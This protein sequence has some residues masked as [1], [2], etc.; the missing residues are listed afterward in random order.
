MGVPRSIAEVGTDIDRFQPPNEDWLALDALVTEF[1]ES[2]ATA[3]DA[4]TLLRVFERYPDEDGA[5]VFW[6]LVHGLEEL[7]GYEPYVFAA[8]RRAPNRFNLVLVQRMVNS[9]LEE[10]AGTP[11]LPLLQEVVDRPD[12]PENLRRSIADYLA[13][14][15]DPPGG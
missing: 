2:G 9:G 3:W 12:T 1:L 5:G 14:K 11:L 7:P 13:K 6:A 4:E 15:R 8:V 10:A